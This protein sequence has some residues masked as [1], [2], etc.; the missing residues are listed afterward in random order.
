MSFHT[1][2]LYVN[3]H[4]LVAVG[5]HPGRGSPAAVLVWNLQRGPGT[6]RRGRVKAWTRLGEQRTPRPDGR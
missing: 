1:F 3:Q 4:H 6:H 2:C 5:V